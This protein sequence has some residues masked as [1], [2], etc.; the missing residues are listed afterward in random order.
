[1]KRVFAML[2]VV[3]M[4]LASV[5]VAEE[6]DLSG[7]NDEEIVIL[8]QRVQEEIVARHIEKTATMRSGSYIAGRDFPA[9][10]YVYTCLAAGNEWGNLTIHAE[11]GAGQMLFWKVVSAPED[12]KEPLSYFVTLKSGD[13]LKSDVPFSLTIYAGMR[14]Q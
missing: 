12:G 14:F 2:A 4:L 8:M 9:G 13:R 10:S 1:M 11:E 7:L 3:L 6:I 5:A